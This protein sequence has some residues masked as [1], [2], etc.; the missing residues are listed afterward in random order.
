MTWYK[1]TL[2]I[3][4]KVIV[5]AACV[6]FLIRTASTIQLCQLKPQYIFTILLTG[7]FYFLCTFLLAGAWRILVFLRH[8]KPAAFSPV[9]SVY[10]LSA[11]AKYIPSNVMHFAARHFLCR[12]FNLSQKE[13][14]FSNIL[15]IC[16]VLTAAIGLVGVFVFLKLVSL[17]EVFNGNQQIIQRL[18]VALCIGIVIS[19]TIFI[20]QKMKIIKSG[21]HDLFLKIAF[22][23]GIYLFFFLI[24][25]LVFW[26]QF[27]AM[28]IGMPLAPDI[29][30]K[31]VFC[32]IFAWTLGFVTPG[33][34]GGLGVREAVMVSILEPIIGPDIAV[35][36]AVLFRISTLL[37]EFFGYLFAK[38][39]QRQGPGRNAA[40]L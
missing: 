40:A 10:F 38:A 21:Q 4:F 1:N 6:A 13:V 15:E 27:L 14:L 39:V 19:M 12:K 37:G 32:Y 16:L 11:L 9:A 31:Y 18:I 2:Y 17:P 7:A 26:L 25:G 3:V 22:V 35:I 20:W 8:P 30:A 23:F 28:D 36:G 34:P 5:A 33:V 29:V 24:A